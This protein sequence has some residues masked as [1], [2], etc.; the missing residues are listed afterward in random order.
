MPPSGHVAGVPLLNGCQHW[1]GH[2]GPDQ[3]AACSPG[4][5]QASTEFA[6]HVERQ[7]KLFL[8]L[9]Q[10][11][12]S[13]TAASTSDHLLRHVHYAWEECLRKGRAG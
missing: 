9:L 5:L 11:R 4:I 12:Q 2:T 3:G 13:L 6:L 1:W 7:V 8:G 10:L